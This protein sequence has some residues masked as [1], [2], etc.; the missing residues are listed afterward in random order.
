MERKPKAWW[1]LRDDLPEDEVLVPV[2][3]AAGTVMAAR[4][5]HMSKELLRELNLSLDHLIG[6]GI[7]RPGK[8]VGVP[9]DPH[10]RSSEGMAKPKAWWVLR[11]DLPDGELLIPVLT[12]DG[13]VMAARA[14]HMSD[15][16]L[17]ALNDYLDH[18]IGT[19]M[20]QPGT[21]R[22][23]AHSRS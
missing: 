12:P 19:G 5:G 2:V 4:R 13:T 17:L 18:L 16:L 8:E 3:T 7:W 21:A 1:V 22:P 9:G 11:D 10:E 15:E 23:L 20:W 6:V 14:G